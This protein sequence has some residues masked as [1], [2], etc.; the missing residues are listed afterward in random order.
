MNKKHLMIILVI[1]LVAFGIYFNYGTDLNFS[2]KDNSLSHPIFG[3]P[4][5]DDNDPLSV[6]PFLRT[7]PFDDASELELPEGTECTPGCHTQNDN[8]CY[9]PFYVADRP[10]WSIIGNSDSGNSDP[11]IAGAPDGTIAAKVANFNDIHSR[12][13]VPMSVPNPV[14]Y[15]IGFGFYI[16]SDSFDNSGIPNGHQIFSMRS[17]Y[18]LGCYAPSNQQT[19]RVTINYGHVKNHIQ[20]DNWEKIIVKHDVSSGEV[21]IFYNGEVIK[22]YSNFDEGVSSHQFQLRS[23]SAGASGSHGAIWFNNLAVGTD[24]KRVNNYQGNK[25]KPSRL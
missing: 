2:P 20:L 17:K 11:F 6:G 14:V 1:V 16:E 25:L 12:V 7:W 15:Y 22:S 13:V 3:D 19:N 5:V 18:L 21:D 10:H 9:D 23:R 8:E 4:L 24:Y